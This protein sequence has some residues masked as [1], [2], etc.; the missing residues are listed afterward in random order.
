MDKKCSK[1]AGTIEELHAA[2]LTP[3]SYSRQQTN[4]NTA[5]T[6]QDNNEDVFPEFPQ[7]MDGE[8]QSASD[9][10]MS[11]TTNIS[12][13]EQQLM[14]LDTGEDDIFID[15]IVVGEEVLADEAIPKRNKICKEFKKQVNVVSAILND[16]S[17]V[18]SSL[19]NASQGAGYITKIAVKQ[20]LNVE[21]D[22]IYASINSQESCYPS[23]SISTNTDKTTV[24]FQFHSLPNGQAPLIKMQIEG[25]RATLD[26]IV[27]M[28]LSAFIYDNQKASVPLNLEIN[29]MDTQITVRD[30]KA[31]S[32]RIKLSGCVIEQTEEDDA[33]T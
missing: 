28:H 12:E 5:T 2:C 8:L 3:I 23:G 26:D 32:V 30:P 29:L 33:T 9:E 17:V 22:E 7:Q 20:Y 13:E 11:V 25:F 18:V 4:A 24:K 10:T 21:L 1:K 16:M 6:F 27:L 15:E 31:K 19:N 14:V